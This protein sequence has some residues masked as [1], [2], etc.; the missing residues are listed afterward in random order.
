[1]NTT[2]LKAIKKNRYIQGVTPKGLSQMKK[3]RH[4]KLSSIIRIQHIA[5]LYQISHLYSRIH[6][7]E[8]NGLRVSNIGLQNDVHLCFEI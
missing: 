7:N 6:S 5:Y 1:M 3:S 8:M 2:P 4:M